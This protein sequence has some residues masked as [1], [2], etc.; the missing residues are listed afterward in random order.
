MVETAE[1]LEDYLEGLWLLLFIAYAMWRIYS[2]VESIYLN[3]DLPAQKQKLEDILVTLEHQGF[4]EVEKKAKDKL[5]KVMMKI[6][7]T[8]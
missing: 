1:G 5:E 7:E 6:V 8:I 2:T 3:W 4:E